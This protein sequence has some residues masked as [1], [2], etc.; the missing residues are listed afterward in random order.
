[1]EVQK[2]YE[3]AAYEGALPQMESLATAFAAHAI[4][5]LGFG[6]DVG[7]RFSTSQLA[8][9]LGVAAAHARLLERVL[10]IL[11]DA[12]VLDGDTEDWIVRHTP[13]REDLT[14]HGSAIRASYP[15]CRR[16]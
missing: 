6:F 9:E 3:L 16:R 12:E 2:E 4:Q 11:K 5:E 1:M 15:Q 14:H 7:R 13:V 10:G 8:Q